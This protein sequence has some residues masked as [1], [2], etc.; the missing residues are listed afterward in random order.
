MSWM[1]KHLKQF[2]CPRIYSARHFDE[3]ATG[4]TI[5]QLFLG[6]LN[7]ASQ[8]PDTS[9]SYRLGDNQVS[10]RM[11]GQK[12]GL[13]SDLDLIES[14]RVRSIAQLIGSVT[15][16]HAESFSSE[17]TGAQPLPYSG[18]VLFDDCS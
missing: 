9:H 15:H 3:Y 1:S 14:Y 2:L 12:H 17:N 4:P 5:R 7:K 8:C 6:F 18:S 16:R 13:G 10:A 11:A